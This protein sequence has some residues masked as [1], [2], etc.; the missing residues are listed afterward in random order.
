MLEVAPKEE[1]CL[2]HTVQIKY[3]DEGRGGQV[4]NYHL[5]KLPEKFQA[6]PPQAVE[7]IVCRVKPIDNEIEWNPKVSIRGALALSVSTAQL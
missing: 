5:L 3:I 2:F 6:L 7:F 1:S 4:Q